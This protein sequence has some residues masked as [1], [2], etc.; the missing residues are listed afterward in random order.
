VA[1]ASNSDL[2]RYRRNL[3]NE[4]DSAVLYRILAEAESSQELAEVYARLAA[5][6]ER[7]AEVWRTKLGSIGPAGPSEAPGAR[8]RFLGWLARRFGTDAVLP[9]ILA[10]EA[11]D[12]HSYEEQPE[13]PAAGMPADERSHGRVSSGQWWRPAAMA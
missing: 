12:T 2:H 5:V 7:H 8:V 3:R 1:T 13:A 4:V 11:Q 9:L 6:E 10:G